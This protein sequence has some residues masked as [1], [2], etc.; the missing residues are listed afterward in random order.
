MVKQ[1]CFSSMTPE[2]QTRARAAVLKFSRRVCATNSQSGAGIL[3]LSDAY[4]KRRTLYVH[5]VIATQRLLHRQPGVQ[6]S[7]RKASMLAI[8]EVGSGKT[9]TAILVMAAVRVANPYR[10]DTKTII[11]CPLSVLEVWYDTVQAWTTLGNRVLM[12]SKQ[13]QL[14][15]GAIEDAEVIITTPDVLMQAFKSF[16]YMS[17]EP[18]DAAKPKMQ[19]FK[20]GVAPSNHK[21]LAELNGELPPVHPMFR[22]LAVKPSRIALVAVDECHAVCNPN[23]IKGHVISMFTKEATYKLGLTGTPVTSKPSQLSDLARALDAEAK[24]MHKKAFFVADKGSGERALRKES[25]KEFHR[26]LVDRVGIEFLDLPPKVVHLVNYAPFVGLLPDGTTDAEAIQ[27]H[28]DALTIAQRLAGMLEASGRTLE[29]DEEKWGEEQRRAFAAIVKLGNME[30]SSELGKHGAKA[31]EKDSSLYETAAAAPSQ[32]MRLT[33]RLIASRQALGHPRIVVFCESTTQL[34]ILRLFLADKGVGVLFLFD[35]K[36]KGKHRNA[37]VREFLGCDCGVLLLSGAGSMGITLCPGCEVLISVGSLPWNATTIDQAFGRIY[38]IGQNKPVEIIQLAAER[39]VTLVKLGLHNDK[40]DRLAAA[41][42]DEDFSN[43]EEGDNK[44][45]Q[46]MDILRACVPL[47]ARGNYQIAPEDVY[48]LRAYKR[49]IEQC[50]A[51]GVP[52]PPPP[53]DLPQ[54]PLLADRVV[55]PAVRSGGGGG[56]GG[57]G[58]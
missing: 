4:N 12:A 48:K 29:S 46:T 58:R 9:I 34:R 30:F 15:E 5:Q 6:W 8:H 25:V 56:G 23:T 11:I 45:R 37:M 13:M 47:D 22:L 42:A 53:L 10:K 27:N 54:P 2:A 21:R 7:D 38:R 57:G 50:D 51:N 26:E 32:A 20:H 35:G 28:N 55:L 3:K 40:R 52:R 43:F 24:D 1:K 16:A 14:T 49:L 41:A 17:K 44:W 19:R 33:L 18:E 39:S 31:F 36:L